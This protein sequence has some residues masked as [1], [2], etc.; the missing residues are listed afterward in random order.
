[1]Y[2]ITVRQ[3][4][5]WMQNPIPADQLTPASLGCGL[6]GGAGP[7]PGTLPAALT[8]YSNADGTGSLTPGPAPEQYAY[9]AEQ[10]GTS[11]NEGV[12]RVGGMLACTAP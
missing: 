11:D 10:Q 2:F 8:T 4:I 1:V 5:A 12:I 7:S 9:G 3:L 6:Q